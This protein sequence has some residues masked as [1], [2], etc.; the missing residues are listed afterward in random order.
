[1]IVS[2]FLGA[3]ILNY[4]GVNINSFAVSGALLPFTLALE[5]ILGK[6][7]KA[8]PKSPPQLPH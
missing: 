6:L 5:I 1:M 4:L 7:I 8:K 2:L 3:C